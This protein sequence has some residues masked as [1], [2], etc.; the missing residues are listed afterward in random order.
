MLLDFDKLTKQ[1]NM[2]VTGVIH[3]G[4]HHGKE[5][6]IYTRYNTIKEMYFFEPDPNSFSILQEKIKDDPKTKAFNIA[7]GSERCF[8]SFYKSSN[9]GES[10]SLLEPLIHLQQYPHIKFHKSDLVAVNRLDNFVLPEEL[11][12]INIDVQGFELEVF[13]GAKKT[14]NQI[15]YI[16]AEV[17]RDEVYKNCCMVTD[18]DAFLGKYGFKRVETTWD[19]MTWGDAFYIKGDVS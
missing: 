9:Q 7:L 6:D 17:N 14:L 18:L 3:I 2:N 11:N 13:K 10:S 15:E 19:G 8:M 12:L 16:I 4:A 5:Y 1:Y